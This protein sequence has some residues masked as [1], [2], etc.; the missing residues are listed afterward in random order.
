MAVPESVQT[1]L[2]RWCADRIPHAE[3]AQRQ[4]GYTIHG[5]DVTV[6]DRRAPTYPELD[7]EWTSTALAQL[8]CNDP[9]P[10]RWSLY[11]PGPDGPG[12]W[13]R[14]GSDSDDP[15]VLLDRVTP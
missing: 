12:S 11:R 13:L 2:S 10:G 4:I 8:R 14:E 1:R 9:E 3:R 5:D 6:V 7:L 15:F